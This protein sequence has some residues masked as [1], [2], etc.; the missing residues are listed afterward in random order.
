VVD[1]D[2]LVGNAAEMGD[3]LDAALQALGAQDV[4]GRGLMR[5]LQ[6][7]EPR[8]K[9]FQQACLEAGV[10]VNA[11]DDHTVRFV[12]PLI[13]SPDQIEHAHSTMQGLPR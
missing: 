4:R 12:P 10:L 9:A 2:G 11:V 3:L 8:A 1:R 13:I 5:A 6:F 7:A